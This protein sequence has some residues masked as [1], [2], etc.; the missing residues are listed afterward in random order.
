MYVCVREYVSTSVCVRA[1]VHAC[2]CVC[3]CVCVCDVS[4]KAQYFTVSYPLTP[5]Q[6]RFSAL[7]FTSCKG[8]SFV[9]VHFR[10]RDSTVPTGSKP[11][12]C[13]SCPADRL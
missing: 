10:N 9:N 4:L 3:V 7:I 12:S 5:G 8:S 11:L 2:V 1:C 6:L 13:R